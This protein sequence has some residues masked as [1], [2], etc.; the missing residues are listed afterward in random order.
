M[1]TSAQRPPSWKLLLAFAIIY[2]VWGSTYFAIRVGVR[3][4]PPLLL[5]SMRFLV[6]GLVLYGWT[7]LRGT[8]A[9]TRREW[10][11]ASG[12]G[13]LVFLLD[14][15][16]LFWA[17]QRVPSGIAAVVLATIPVFIS[18]LEIAILRT[19][20]LTARLGL[21]LLVGIGGV[22]VLMNPSASF[23]EAPINRAG[24]AALLVAAFSWSLATVLTCKVQ[25]PQSKSM[26]SA[27]QMTS[28]GVQLL[29]AA[30]VCG[31]FS[32]FHAGAVSWNAWLALLYLIIAGSI[33]GFT[34]YLW[35]LH[36]Q[37]PTKVGTYAYVNPVVAVLLGYFLGGEPIG[38]R[39]VGGAA[40]VLV[41]V[42]AINTMP[43]KG[44]QNAPISAASA[45]HAASAVA[46]VMDL[47]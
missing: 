2:V 20:R 11:A 34:A 21:A 25:L 39:T 24:A 35:L 46:P 10:V 26:S 18:I 38:P 5:A 36:Y 1:E 45:D 37:S 32:R 29:L 30:A 6:A 7:R 23:G 14:Y 3:E 27:A 33:A 28:G 43:R 44:K 13:T 47:E 19:Q 31:E 9:P 22:T 12:M 16:L 4:V 40:L 42:I 15:G 41:S 8:P 17:E